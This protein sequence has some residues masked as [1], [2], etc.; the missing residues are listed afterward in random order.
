MAEGQVL[1]NPVC[2]GFID[3]FRSAQGA[4][5]L[6]ALGLEEVALAGM[7]AHHLAGAGYLKS[8]CHRFFCFNTFRASHI[9]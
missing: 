6:G 9:A 4:S 5:A 8:F 1:K 3:N 2:V 7:G